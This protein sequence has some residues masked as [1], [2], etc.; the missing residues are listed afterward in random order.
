MHPSPAQLNPPGSVQ[1]S[2]GVVC[3][4][5]SLVNS[6]PPPLTIM[7]EQDT[8]VL[9]E[10]SI[11]WSYMDRL[12]HHASDASISVPIALE[13]LALGRQAAQRGLLRQSIIELGTAAEAILQVKLGI[14]SLERKTLGML[15]GLMGKDLLPSDIGTM[16]LE[17]RNA[18]IHK[19]REPLRTEVVR[20]AEI[21]QQLLD[22]ELPD[23]ARPNDARRAHRSQK[24]DITI[25]NA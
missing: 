9:S 20:A 8:S 15:I 1:F 25:V 5:E 11:R 12:T 24:M 13:F 6:S 17:P 22:G 3:G 7:T 23:W 14:K 2:W 18:A 21:V 4:I 19:G 10:L 16:L